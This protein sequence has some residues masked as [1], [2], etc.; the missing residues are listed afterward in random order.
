MTSDAYPPHFAALCP[1][2]TMVALYLVFRKVWSI[3]NGHVRRGHQRD[4]VYD[5]FR[6]FDP[7]VW[8]VVPG[9]DFTDITYHQRK[10]PWHGADSVRRPEVRNTFDQIP[11]MNSTRL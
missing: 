4:G 2:L 1:V 9:F 8:D 6:D 10:G 7:N 5:G 3:L 11:S